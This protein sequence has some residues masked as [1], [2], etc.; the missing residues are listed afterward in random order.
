MRKPFII[1]KRAGNKRSH[2]YVAFLNE[3]T[4]QYQNRTS[5]TVLQRE[6]APAADDMSTTSRAGVEQIARL[7]LSSRGS[8]DQKVVGPYLESFW[9]PD[10]EYAKRTAR[11]HRPLSRVYLTVRRSAVKKHAIPWLKARGHYNKPASKVTSGMIE[12]MLHDLY[13]QGVTSTTCNRVRTS[14]SKPFEELRRKGSIPA[15]PVGNTLRFKEQPQRRRILTLPEAKRFFQA[16]TTDR[17][18]RTA[19]LLAMATGMRIGEIIGLQIQDLKQETVDETTYYWI[20]LNHAWT[21]ADGL[22]A[23]KNESRGD[24][25]LPESVAIALQELHQSNPFGTDH[26]FWGDLCHR[27]LDARKIRWEYQNILERIGIDR[28]EQQ[29][30][31]LS[32]HAWRHFYASYMSAAATKVLRHANAETTERYSHLTPEDRRSISQQATTMLQKADV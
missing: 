14:L 18:A 31:G 4:G 5:A 1:Y 3:S 25:P 11:S 30:R 22:H 21:D 9:D 16:E 6:L 23:P 13:E 2:Y 8:S 7:A 24:V 10:G 20:A 29:R 27:P 12:T 17:R 15:N 32:F 28:S 26:V 19:C